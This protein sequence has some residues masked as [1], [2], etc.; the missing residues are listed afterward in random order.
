MRLREIKRF[1]PVEIVRDAEFEPLGFLIDPQPRMLVFAEAA[2]AAEKVARLPG[3]SAVITVALL[4]R[5]LDRVPGLA[6]AGNPRKAFF[7]LHNHLAR[8]TSFCWRDYTTEIDSAAFVHPGAF[9]AEKNVRIGPGT[10]VGPNACIHERCL[11]GE[12]VVLGAGV[13]LGSS[14]FQCALFD[15]EMA[16][17]E[18][19]GGVH[20]QDGAHLLANAVAA[21]AVFRQLTT[22]GSGSRVGNLAFISHNVRTG[23]RCFIGHGSVIN[24]NVVMGSDV[25]IGPGSTLVNCIQVGDGA[26]ISLGST[27][28]ADVAAGERVTGNFA[29][30]HRRFMRRLAANR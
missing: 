20:V 18:H 29:I 23:P 17:M 26:Q 9:V 4:C 5:R 10:R 27:V 19:A 1:L 6:L 24:G 8:N 7:D 28:I 14:G 21:A 12:G 3:I 2:S 30:P 22:L 11:V 16:D 13:V 25:W 15:G